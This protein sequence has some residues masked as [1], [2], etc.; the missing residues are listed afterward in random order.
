MDEKKIQHE[1]KYTLAKIYATSDDFFVN[2]N[3]NPPA[4]LGRME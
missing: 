3:T 1:G 4:K 2:E